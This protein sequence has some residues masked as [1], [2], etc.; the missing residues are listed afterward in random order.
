M[1]ED[2]TEGRVRVGTGV[3]LF[4]VEAG[5]GDPVLLVPGFTMDHEVFVGQLRGLSESYRVIALDPRSHGRS[6]RSDHGNTYHQQGADIAAFL[7]ALD[8]DQVALCGW[9]FGGLATY[10]Y[11]AEH[12]IERLRAIVI[13]DMTPKPLGTGTNGEWSDGDEG[14]Y[15][16]GMVAGLLRDHEGF[17]RSGLDSMLSRPPSATDRAWFERMQLQ[18]PLDAAIPLLMSAILSDYSDIA[19]QL[20]GVLPVANVVRDNWMSQARPWLAV[21]APH[22]QIWTMPS[23]LGFW[24]EPAEF[25]DRL[26]RFLADSPAR[27]PSPGLIDR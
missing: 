14:V 10:A 19:R 25:N 20:D 13:L 5:V 12:G 1:G 22:S 7:T 17:F 11:A 24:E 16:D 23:H 18:T 27:Q 8:L 2:L 21:N 26:R 9:S 15:L 4:Y 6:T 3:D